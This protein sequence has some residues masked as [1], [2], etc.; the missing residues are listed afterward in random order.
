MLHVVDYDLMTPG[1]NHK[2]L[3]N[4]LRSMGAKRTMRSQWVV[5]SDLT[6]KQL[7][8]SLQ[9]K[10]LDENDRL[11]VVCLDDGDWASFNLRI[12]LNDL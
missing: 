7:R 11:L 1:Q 5:N 4:G 10:F 2:Q 8:D 9:E 6:A 3:R 12:D